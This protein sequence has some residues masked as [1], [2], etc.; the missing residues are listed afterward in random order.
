MEKKETMSNKRT[1]MGKITYIITLIFLFIILYFAYQ[2]YQKNNFN[3]FIRSEANLYTS[4]FKRDKNEKYSK[5]RSYQIASEDYNDAMFYKE[6]KVEKNTPYRVTCMVKTSNVETDGE[7]SGIGA[8]I[9]IEGTTERS[10]A[11]QGTSDWQKIELIFNSKNRESVSVGFRLGGY[12]GKAKGEAWFSDFTLEEG[13]V[14]NDNEWDFACFIFNQTDVN[15]NG[16]SIQIEMTNNDIRD[17]NNTIERFKD[18]CANLSEGKMT[19]NCDVY[20]IDTPLN[21]LSYDEEFGYYVSAENIESQI[22]DTI[23]NNDYDHIFVIVRLR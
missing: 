19:A 13:I 7:N 2:Y 12:L 1:K 16:K 11:I 17:I 5:N 4:E 22:K 23:A 18:S 21:Q 10:V 15:I 6:V 3:D 20:Q 8:Q 14:E 9:S